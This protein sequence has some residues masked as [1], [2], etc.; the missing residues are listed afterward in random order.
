MSFLH[1][2]RFCTHNFIFL[3]FK[4]LWNDTVIFGQLN[5]SLVSWNVVLHEYQKKYFATQDSLYHSWKCSLFLCIW[6][7][8]GNM[9]PF[10]LTIEKMKLIRTGHYGDWNIYRS[11]KLF[12]ASGKFFFPVRQLT[13]Y[14]RSKPVICKDLSTPDSRNWRY[15]SVSCTN[16]ASAFVWT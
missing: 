9:A 2:C 12:V 16:G 5:V 8:N 4:R 10:L 3:N 1:H 11:I 15:P 7:L 14:I 6:L 13:I